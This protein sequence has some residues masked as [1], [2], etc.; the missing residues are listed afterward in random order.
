MNK[1]EFYFKKIIGKII[2][3]FK[4]HQMFCDI[5]TH[6]EGDELKLKRYE[7]TICQRMCGY[8]LK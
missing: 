1:F 7:T 5:L 8:Y 6:F 2:C 3:F 4:G